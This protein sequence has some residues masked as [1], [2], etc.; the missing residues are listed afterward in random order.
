MSAP[1][2]AQKVVQQAEVM[3][4]FQKMR[5]GSV[6]PGARCR[7][8]TIGVVQVRRRRLQPMRSDLAANPIEVYGF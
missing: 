6:Q 5:R 2:V 3:V 1:R 7:P 8:L 4:S